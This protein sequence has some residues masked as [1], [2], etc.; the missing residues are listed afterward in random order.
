M[1]IP[2]PTFKESKNDYVSRIM[3]ELKKEYPDEKQRVAIALM[4]WKRGRSK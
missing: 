2:K 4:Q 1:P 3:H